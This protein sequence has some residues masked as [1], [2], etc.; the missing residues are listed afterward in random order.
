LK[1]DITTTIT[2]TPSITPQIEINV[3]TDTNERLGRR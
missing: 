2:A 1:I 3:M